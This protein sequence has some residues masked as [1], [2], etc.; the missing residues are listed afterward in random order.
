MLAFRIETDD[1]KRERLTE[2]Y[3][4]ANRKDPG[5]LQKSQKEKDYQKHLTFQP[6][7]KQS[8]N[9]TGARRVWTSKLAISPIFPTISGIRVG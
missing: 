9:C 2:H 8:L 5:L 7:N 3:I 1:H 4:Q 6:R